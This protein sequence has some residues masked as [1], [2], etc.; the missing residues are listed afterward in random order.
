MVVRGFA[1]DYR[2]STTDESLPPRRLFL[3][4]PHHRDL[5]KSLFKRRSLHL[6]RHLSHD[7]FRYHASAALMPFHAN[8]DRNVEKQALHIVAIILGQLDP[9]MPVMR[10]EIG[11]V[12]IIHG[13]PRN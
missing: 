9:T 6:A 13:P 1:I 2:L 3:L 11:R 7:V 12:H 5:R 10:S 4:H 8:L